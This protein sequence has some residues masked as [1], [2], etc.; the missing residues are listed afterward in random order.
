MCLCFCLH[1]KGDVV[2][3]YYSKDYLFQDIICIPTNAFYSGLIDLKLSI[4]HLCQILVVV[5]VHE[6]LRAEK[7]CVWAMDLLLVFI[8]SFKSHVQ[9]TIRIEDMFST[10]NTCVQMYNL[11]TRTPQSKVI[12][13]LDHF[14]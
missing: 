13:L 10:L 7:Y 5:V 14:I 6:Q 3:K 12:M 2:I 1:L 11:T 4:H 9:L 8:L